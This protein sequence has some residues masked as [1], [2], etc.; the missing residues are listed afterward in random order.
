MNKGM[1]KAEMS[2]PNFK[3]R[4]AFYFDGRYFFAW[5][6]GSEIEGRQKI[7]TNNESDQR[8][9]PDGYLTTRSISSAVTK[10]ARCCDSLEPELM[11]PNFGM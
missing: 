10:C 6:L 2:D 9:D 1:E 5:D 3:V 4:P 8:G 7:C 11:F